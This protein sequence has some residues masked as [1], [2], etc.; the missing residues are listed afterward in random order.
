MSAR[1]FRTA[2]LGLGMLAGLAAA[3]PS[4]PALAGG[5]G[6]HHAAH[7]AA[8]A[9]SDPASEWGIELVAVR[10]SAAGSM[11]DLRVRVTDA[12]RAA[13]YLDRALQPRLVH[14]A[15]G[16]VLSVASGGKIGTLRQ[17]GRQLRNGQVLS[18]LFANP[19][20]FVKAGDPVS[21]SLGELRLDGLA[22]EG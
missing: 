19:G 11:I 6:G 17:T 4:L 3:V 2:A 13:R 12:E 21:F 8:P 9:P 7:A 14:T 5:E 1:R 16:A 15:S 20:R 18:D 22:V 10:L